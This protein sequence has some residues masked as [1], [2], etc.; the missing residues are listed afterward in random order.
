[1]NMSTHSVFMLYP[2]ALDRST[3]RGTD[4][5]VKHNGLL[6]CESGDHRLRI[7]SRGCPQG[8]GSGNANKG[9]PERQGVVI[10]IASKPTTSKTS[11]QRV[12]T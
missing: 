1:M 10:S 5:V 3:S 7:A 2:G 8:H 6:K 9:Q 11:G 4:R 12:H